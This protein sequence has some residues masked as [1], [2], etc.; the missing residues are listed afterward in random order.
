MPVLRRSWVAVLLCALTLTLP[1]PLPAAAA[2]TLVVL[3][4]PRP[5]YY[6]ETTA[7]SGRT[8]VGGLVGGPAGRALAAAGIAVEWRQTPFNR[9]IEMIRAS[10]APLCAL[11]WFRTPERRAFARFSRPLYR[12]LAQ[13]ALTTGPLPADTLR[14]LLGNREI[15]LGV[16]LGYSYGAYVDGLIA[17]IDPNL[18]STT[19]DTEGMLRML[20]GGRFDLMLIAAEE[21]AEVLRDFPDRHRLSSQALSDLP[22]GQSRHLMCTQAV[23]EATLAALDRALA[24]IVPDPPAAP[25]ATH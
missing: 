15:R 8:D 11:G 17:A 7:E 18:V 12:D 9:Q 22:P 23:P 19:Q 3:Y 6:V 5:P 13:I 20:I 25:A 16:K 10:P 24:E 1:L 21:A 14:A 4:Q 2:E